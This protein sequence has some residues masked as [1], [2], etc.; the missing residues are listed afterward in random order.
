MNNLESRKSGYR[1][2]DIVYRSPSTRLYLHTGV[3]LRAV[4]TLYVCTSTELLNIVNSFLN[5]SST[6]QLQCHAE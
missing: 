6:F 2:S 3:Q 5:C 4:C 1:L